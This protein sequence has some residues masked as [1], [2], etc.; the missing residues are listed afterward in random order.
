MC[1]SERM[2]SIDLKHI[3]CFSLENILSVNKCEETKEV[4]C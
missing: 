4:Y 2:K 1:N 3:T